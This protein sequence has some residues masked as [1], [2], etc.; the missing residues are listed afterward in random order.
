MFCQGRQDSLHPNSVGANGLQGF[1]QQ[2]HTPEYVMEKVNSKG[3]IRR[4]AL[5]YQCNWHVCKSRAMSCSELSIC[6]VRQIRPPNSIDNDKQIWSDLH[7]FKFH[8]HSSRLLFNVCIVFS[9][10]VCCIDRLRWWC[11]VLYILLVIYVNFSI[12]AVTLPCSF[13]QC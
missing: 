1:Y 13:V 6:L 4:A 12:I 8:A 2:V 10:Y 9:I 3:V 11:N 7:S 5:P